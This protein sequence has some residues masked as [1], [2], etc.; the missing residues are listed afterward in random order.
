MRQNLD[1]RTPPRASTSTSRRCPRQR[2]TTGIPLRCPDRHVGSPRAVAASDR[3][4]GTAARA[5]TKR[6]HSRRHDRHL[7]ETR[8]KDRGTERTASAL[9]LDDV[10]QVKVV[11]IKKP[12][13]TPAIPAPR[14]VIP[15][16][17]KAPG[18]R[19][20]AAGFTRRFPLPPGL[21]SD[22]KPDA[23]YILDTGVGLAFAHVDNL[24]LLAD[25]YAGQ[26]EYVDDVR[27]EWASQAISPVDPLR[28]GHTPDQKAAHENLVRLRA[29]AKK[30]IEQMPRLVGEAVDLGFEE[31][32]NVHDLITE[33]NRLHPARKNTG[34]DRGESASVRL[35]ELRREYTEVVVLCTN[36]DRGRRLAGAH[37]IAYRNAG[38][39]L[40]EMT[41]EG[42]LTA[43]DAHAHYQQMVQLSGIAEWAR[44]DTVDHFR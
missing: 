11:N 10:A 16:K 27:R 8:E 36:D 14:S 22:R 37:G 6:R 13:R 29:A 15:P 31:L 23:V 44:M 30:C 20:H 18:P 39:V 12:Y 34:G 2:D 3:A 26:L 24:A 35:C 40:C 42:R 19:S 25:H 5:T 41:L 1:T 17:P 32:E 38:H 43:E 9:E 4:R 7:Q 21:G 33:I 28:P